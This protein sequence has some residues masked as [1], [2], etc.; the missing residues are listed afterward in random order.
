MNAQP[1]AAPGG[2]L[3][4]DVLD[5]HEVRGRLVAQHVRVFESKRFEEPA[6]PR[7]HAS[8]RLRGARRVVPATQPHDR[9]PPP[10]PGRSS[11]H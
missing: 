10:E 11:V 8:A 2:T 7:A 3:P 5:R 1:R 6:S 4:V 9:I